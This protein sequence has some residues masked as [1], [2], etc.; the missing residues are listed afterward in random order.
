MN[1]C[2]GASQQIRQVLPF[3]RHVAKESPVLAVAAPPYMNEISTCAFCACWEFF[4][5]LC[6]ITF[7]ETSTTVTESLSTLSQHCTARCLFGKSRFQNDE[8][9][10]LRSQWVKNAGSLPEWANLKT[11]LGRL[12]PNLGQTDGPS[13]RSLKP[14]KPAG[15][16]TFLVWWSAL[17]EKLPAGVQGGDYMTLNTSQC[18][19]SLLI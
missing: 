12:Q 9:K 3:Y 14:R 11:P 10:S 17:W 16:P 19:S 18:L 4:S 1:V 2:L 5:L 15:M 13:S 8:L 6:S 7:F